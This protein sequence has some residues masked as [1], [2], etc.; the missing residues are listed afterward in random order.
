MKKRY[1]LHDFLLLTE[2][3]LFIIL[4]IGLF[5]NLKDY[6]LYVFKIIKIPIQ[7]DYGEGFL[8]N[9]VKLLLD[10]KS[11]F[12]LYTPIEKVPFTILNYPPLYVYVVKLCSFKPL[13]QTGR[14]ISLIATFF[15]VIFISFSA[16][17]I[18]K[19]L[20]IGFF[21]PFIFLIT[22]A[23]H[24]WSALFRVDMLALFFLFCS[25]YLYSKRVN[26]FIVAF[27][28]F[29]AVYTR[30]TLLLFPSTLFLWGLIK[31]EKYE[32]KIFLYWLIISFITFVFFNYK[33]HGLFFLHTVI[34]NQNKMLWEDLIKVWIKHLFYFNFL[35]LVT[36][37]IAI[38]ILF[39]NRKKHPQNVFWIIYT[40]LSCVGI[41]TIAKIGAAV[42]YLLEFYAS[43]VLI[44]TTAYLQLE[45][46]SLKICILIFLTLF[47][48]RILNLRNLVWTKLPT[49]SDILEYKDTVRF[50]KSYKYPVISYDGSLLVMA[51][52]PIIY[53]PFTMAQLHYQKIWDIKYLINYLRNFSEFILIT[54]FNINDKA[55]RYDLFPPEIINLTKEKG[56]LVKTC[57]FYYQNWYYIY[58]IKQR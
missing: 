8:L 49:Y 30:Q 28:L 37:V 24:L 39:M 16:M 18:A 11:I 32:S 25:I 48:F 58:R 19:K 31:K 1:L 15:T 54:N 51:N 21:L 7:I 52:K 5:L 55:I 35:L 50:I 2:R 23:V 26:P 20:D 29:L 46:K 42:N 47:S 10:G 38:I 45:K 36:W 56:K 22:Y 14:I 53:Q 34:A 12:E 3:I 6:L 40:I 41:I 4:F 13:L 57:E 43:V 33:T 27:F 44:I 17:N 9:R